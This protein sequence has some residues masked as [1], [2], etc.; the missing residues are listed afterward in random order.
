MKWGGGHTDY[1]RKEQAFQFDFKRSRGSSGEK[2]EGP[3]SWREQQ[4]QRSGG[5]KQ[6]GELRKDSPGEHSPGKG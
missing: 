1:F 4:V 3:P 6:F 5:M 2:A